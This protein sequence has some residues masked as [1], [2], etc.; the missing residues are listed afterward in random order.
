VGQFEILS[1]RRYDHKANPNTSSRIQG[2]NGE[3]GR[4]RSLIAMNTI[5]SADQH[6]ERECDGAKSK[7]P[8][9]L[10]Q[11]SANENQEAQSS[12]EHAT[13]TK[14][15]PWSKIWSS[16]R[17]FLQKTG[18]YLKK[19]SFTDWIVGIA[20]VVIAFYAI[21]QHV[22]SKYAGTQTD[23]IIA[24][25]ERTATA[26]EGSLGKAQQAFDATTKQAILAERAWFNVF[27]DSEQDSGTKIDPRR[28][29]RTR[30]VYKNVGKT[31]AID[32]KTADFRRLTPGERFGSVKVP[33][34]NFPK[35]SYISNGIIPP[36][37][38]VYSD[39]GMED[40]PPGALDAIRTLS[41]RIYFYGRI[42]YK[43][44]F[45]ADHWMTYC[46]FLLPTGAYQICSENNEIDQNPN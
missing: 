28:P 4:P 44:A 9:P 41:T 40:L 14:K 31:P 26:M 43:D 45:G 22:D 25:D 20:T 24:A 12:N 15:F 32:V 39:F 23:R 21:L 46:R 11:S 19:P 34:F 6:P 8:V 37:G 2:T 35:S 7:P 1:F 3:V 13:V 5:K 33:A 30:I 29:F 36:D 16:L 42:E 10:V 38:S 27:M 18:H 17:W